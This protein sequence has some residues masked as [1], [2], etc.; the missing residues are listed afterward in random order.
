MYVEN[1]ESLCRALLFY[2]RY[3]CKKSNLTADIEGI[4]IYY[5]RNRKGYLIY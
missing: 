2:I 4:T 3:G 5:G 1:V